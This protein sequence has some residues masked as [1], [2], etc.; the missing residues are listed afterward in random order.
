MTLSY[1]IS[2]TFQTRFNTKWHSNLTGNILITG[3][4]RRRQTAHGISWSWI[5]NRFLGDCLFHILHRKHKHCFHHA[6][7]CK[8]PTLDILVN[9]EDQPPIPCGQAMSRQY[10]LTKSMKSI[11]YGFYFL[12]FFLNKFI[13][14]IQ[15]YWQNIKC[16]RRRR[17]RRRF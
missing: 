10:S 17:R 3:L 12:W 7:H 11:I 14:F 16:F 6:H 2:Q 8:S 4:F 1:T 13:C 9:K 15:I 5:F